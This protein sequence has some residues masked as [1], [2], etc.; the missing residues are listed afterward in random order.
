MRSGHLSTTSLR[1]FKTPHLSSFP[2]NLELLQ[3]SLADGW[4]SA[5]FTIRNMLLADHLTSLTPRH[6]PFGLLPL[7]YIKCCI[8]HAY[9]AICHCY[10][11]LPLAIAMCHFHCCLRLPLPLPFGLSASCHFTTSN[12]SF[13]TRIMP[14]TIAIT[15]CNCHL[16][17]PCALFHWRLPFA[18]TVCH[19]HFSASSYYFC[20][21]KCNLFRDLHVTC[22]QRA[23][24]S[25]LRLPQAAH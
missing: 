10:L 25:V 5:T 20:R 22:W 18:V 23:G 14:F 1:V 4:T 12:A 13:A 9:P 7:C 2:E 21:I 15:I 3:Q 19:C 8:H 11:L 17:L 16:S 24:R 6:W